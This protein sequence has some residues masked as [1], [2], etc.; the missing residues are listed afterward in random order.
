[1]YY[2][3]TGRSPYQRGKEHMREIEGVLSHPL[4]LHFW[5]DH[6]GRRQ[7]VLMRTISAHLTAIDRQAG[8]SV[9]IL[10]AAKRQGESL[11]LKSE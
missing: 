10:E 4:V 1:M 2:R 8:E 11:N 7:E 6:D 5:E 9:N 3:E